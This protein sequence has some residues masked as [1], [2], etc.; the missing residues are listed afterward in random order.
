[1]MEVEIELD[2]PQHHAA[3]VAGLA[4]FDS[5]SEPQFR[6]QCQQKK[7]SQTPEK[8]ADEDRNR[9]RIQAVQR[10]FREEATAKKHFGKTKQDGRVISLNQRGLFSF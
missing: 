5:S 10:V 1:M 2:D 4:M 3:L 6:P 8:R 9:R 7:G